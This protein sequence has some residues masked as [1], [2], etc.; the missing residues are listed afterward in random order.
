MILLHIKDKKMVKNIESKE[1]GTY[2]DLKISTPGNAGLAD[3]GRVPI[4]Y[5]NML[6]K[7]CKKDI[8]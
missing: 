6:K 5:I 7:G 4:I 8:R 3:P 1:K 2:K